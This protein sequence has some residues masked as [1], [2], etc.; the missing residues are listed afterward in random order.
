M[1]GNFDGDGW[2]VRVDRD[3]NVAQALTHAQPDRFQDG[4]FTHPATDERDPL[5]RRFQRRQGEM[6]RCRQLRQRQWLRDS[7]DLFSVNADG[8]GARNR[9]QCNFT[10]MRQVEMESRRRCQARLAEWSLQKFNVS[11]RAF[12]KMAEDDAEC[13][14]TRE[15]APA[16]MFV[17]EPIAAL[18]LLMAEDQQTPLRRKIRIG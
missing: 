12:K 7:V 18:H 9:N 13:G 1:T 10:G 16:V 2:A 11:R 6:F 15:I 3:A 17:F 4:F 14:V 8:A 5:R